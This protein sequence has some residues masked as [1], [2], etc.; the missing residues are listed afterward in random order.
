MDVKRKGSQFRFLVKQ[1]EEKQPPFPNIGIPY[2]WQRLGFSTHW[3]SSRSVVLCFD[4]PASLKDSLMASV[5]ASNSRLILDNPFL[6][7]SVLITDVVELYN[8]ALWSWRDLIRDI[9]KV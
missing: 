5:P 8:I 1:P 4:L 6:F 2:C 9:E 3:K 7:H